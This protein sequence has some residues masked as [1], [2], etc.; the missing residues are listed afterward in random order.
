MLQKIRTKEAN[1]SSHARRRLSAAAVG[2][3]RRRTSTRAKAL[4]TA[5]AYCL[6]HYSHMFVGQTPRRLKLSHADWWIVPV[7]L[8]SPCYGVVGEVG[9]VAI[10]ADRN[11]VVGATP[12]SEVA[13]SARQLREEKRDAIEASFLRESLPH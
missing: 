3:Q 7:V 11:T 12:R 9:V 13:V 5:N 10:D 4:I 8:T 2:V 6:R 1:V